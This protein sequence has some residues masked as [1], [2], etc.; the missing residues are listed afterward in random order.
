MM[1]G[2]DCRN[3]PHEILFI[4]IAEN[5]LLPGKKSAGGEWDGRGRGE[6]KF[7]IKINDLHT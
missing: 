7:N 3:F 4:F 5:N 2:P 6:N 1:D